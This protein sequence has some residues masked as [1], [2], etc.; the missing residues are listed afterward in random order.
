MIWVH[1]HV[2]GT[3]AYKCLCHGFLHDLLQLDSVPEWQPGNESS[4]NRINMM[5]LARTVGKTHSLSF[6]LGT[7]KSG[8]TTRYIF[9]CIYR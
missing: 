2:A 9:I 4:W 8:Y 3:N 7:R 6:F 1:G 5:T